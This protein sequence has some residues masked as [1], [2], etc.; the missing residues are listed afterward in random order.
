[1]GR[2]GEPRPRPPYPATHGLWDRP[3]LINNVETFAT[4]RRIVL[5]GAAAF[6]AIGTE[7]SKGTK[8]FALAGK[9]RNTG[10]VEVPMGITLR[11]LVFDIGGGVPAGREF[12]AVQIGG[13]SGGCLPASLLD[14][15]VDYDSLSK[16]GAI[17]GSGGVI[18]LDDA[19]CM[20]NVARFFL[21]FTAD[22]S[23]GRCVPCRVGTQMMLGILN[24]IVQGDGTEDDLTRLAE[25]GEMV[26][27][28]SLCGLGQTAPNPVL[29]TLRYFEGEYRAHIHDRSCPAGVC[30]NLVQYKVI[31]D[32]CRGCDACR[33]ACPTGAAQGTA[34]TPPYRIVDD[35]CIRCGACFDVCP[36]EAVAKLPRQ[37][38]KR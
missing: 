37:T 7:T 3:T 33:R 36:F 6:A 24:R 26:K 34:G 16:H 14:V 21:E 23:C 1:E 5:D 12:K 2:R 9:V 35:Q 30:P 19:A 29:S 38:G 18:V 15:P 10:L 17:M 28:A 8:V 4:V 31:A 13:P 27:S 25:I 11:E 20:V 32:A 22:E